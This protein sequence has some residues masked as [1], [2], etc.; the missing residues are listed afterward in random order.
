MTSFLM[1][2]GEL[3]KAYGGMNG[4]ESICTGIGLKFGVW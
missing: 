2:P 4:V 1:Y 3:A